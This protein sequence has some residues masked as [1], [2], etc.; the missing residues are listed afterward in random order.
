MPAD[1]TGNFGG[2][3]RNDL[4]ELQ[5]ELKL[6]SEGAQDAGRAMNRALGSAG[7][8]ELKLHLGDAVKAGKSLAEV[9]QEDLKSQEG[10]NKIANDYNTIKRA[11]NAVEAQLLVLKRE[12]ELADKESLKKLQKALEHALNLSDNLGV[13]AANAG[14][15]ADETKKVEDAGRGFEKMAKAMERIPIAGKL[16]AGPL[17]EAAQAA[18]EATAEGLKPGE[19]KLK[20]WLALSKSIALTIGGAIVTAAVQASQRLG[21]INKQLGVGIENARGIAKEYENYAR[22]SEDAYIT[23]DKL[24]KANGE[25]NKALGTT[26]AFSGETLDSFIK[27]TE[28]MGVSAQ[29]AAKL[30]T[31]ARTTG[32]NTEEFA[33]NLAKSVFEAG[34]ANNIYISTGT[35]LEKIKEMS[36]AT[37]LILQ[38]NPES[39]G[40]TIA[41]VE[42]LGLSFEQL[43]NTA[44]SL[45]N[46]EESISNELEAELL[47]GRQLNLERARGAALMGD[48]ETLAKELANQVGT[49][50]E[51]GRMNVIQQES[52]AKAFGLS[53]DGMADMLLKQELLNSLG[54]EANNLT[55]EQARKIQE[56]VESGDATSESD[57]LMK[58]QQ[59]QDLA[60]NFKKSVEKLQSA[61]VDFFA[62]FEPALNKIV[63]AIKSLVENKFIGGLAGALTSVGGVAALL[64]VLAT[65]KLQ[66]TRFLPMWVRVANMPGSMTG[67]VTNSTGMPTTPRAPGTMLSRN[68]PGGARYSQ[69]MRMS[70]AGKYGLSR[71]MG[72][73]MGIKGVGIGAL[74]ALAGYGMS[75]WAD[76]YEEGSAANVGLGVAG[77]ALQ[78]A[79]TG[80]MIGSIIP[81]VGTAVG[82]GL[83]AAIGGLNAYLERKDKE[84]KAEK[85]EEQDHFTIMTNEIRKMASKEMEVYMDANKVSL[86]VAQGSPQL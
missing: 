40:S 20:G 2:I 46:F 10:R 86:S 52:L 81:G 82:A 21:E 79:G 32:K 68:L 83:G 18:R 65:S 5:E 77:G 23:T 30:E 7:F 41:A 36:S 66:G 74:G 3:N 72:G 42:K 12:I 6:L 85:K 11:Q 64:G 49:A 33:G 25:L 39:I 61:F 14:K 71:G 29:S 73:A 53:R 37:L 45:L 84:D 27:L 28:Y 24:I 35:A 8:A 47:T 48:Q 70:Q 26:V 78:G 56:M 80:A 62:S 57:A 51:F 43:N 19:A 34:K 1:N 75:E 69:A 50:A 9:T 38:R 44:N 55:S 59:Q 22:N 17:R 58:L 63:D 60:T 67:G 31:L 4:K 15:L 76:T 13:A 16:I 54:E